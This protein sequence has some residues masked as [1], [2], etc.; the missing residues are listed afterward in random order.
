MWKPRA[1]LVEPHCSE[2]QIVIAV[3]LSD[4][5]PTFHQ[6][7]L[8]RTEIHLLPFRVKWQMLVI[9]HNGLF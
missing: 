2:V 7:T 6:N 4:N 5:T 9:H 8:T 3:I 1:N